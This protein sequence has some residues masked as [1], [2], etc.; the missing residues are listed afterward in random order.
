MTGHCLAAWTI[1]QAT[2]WVK[3]TFTP[4]SLSDAVHR[5]A[6]GVEGVDGDRAE[7]GRGG[8][9]KALVHRLG[10]HRRRAAQRL[11]LAAP[12]GRLIAVAAICR[13]EHVAPW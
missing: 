9:R 13:C 1:A 5:L 2:R 6:L 4:R 10:K 8:Y 3:E 7:G 12:P 11:L